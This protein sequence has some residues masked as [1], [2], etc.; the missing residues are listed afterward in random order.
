MTYSLTDDGKTV[1]KGNYG[2]YWWNP[3][4]QLAQDN[5]PNPEIWFRRYV[6]NDLNGDK[7]VSARRRRPVDQFRWWRRDPGD[8]SQSEGQLHQRDSPAGS[9]ARSSRI[10]ACAQAWSTAPRRNL[11]R[12]LQPNRPFSRLHRA[13][14]GSGPWPGRRR[15]QRGRWERV[16]GLQP[17]RRRTGA[18]D[19]EHLQQRRWRA[20][21]TTTRWSSP[22]RSA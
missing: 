20:R 4:A 10:S 15:R 2:K 1:L 9:S 13:G 5:N 12:R 17:E 14:H 19:R 7:L 16:Y 11:A 18:A 3:G 21:A 22:A 6:W 8:R